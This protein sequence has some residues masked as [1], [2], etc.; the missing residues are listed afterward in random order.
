MNVI[1]ATP[2]ETP[3]VEEALDRLAGRVG[4][5]KASQ[6]LRTAIEHALNG[7]VERLR[8]RQRAG[9]TVV[10]GV[11]QTKRGGATSQVELGRNLFGDEFAVR[12]VCDCG[13]RNCVHGAAVA[14]TALLGLPQSIGP[15]E[16]ERAA[17]TGVTLRLAG[18]R[19]EPA[20]GWEEMFDAGI[21]LERHRLPVVEFFGTG[22]DG[23]RTPLTA[24]GALTGDLA[25]QAVE[26]R[27]LLNAALCTTLEPIEGLR[28]PRRTRGH[29]FVVEALDGAT[30]DRAT[31]IQ[32]C[33]EPQEGFARH[34]ELKA[35][36]EK[37]GWTLEVDD[38]WPFRLFDDPIPLTVEFRENDEGG[39]AA[40]P[41]IKL[42]DVEL[43]IEESVNA[44]AKEV[45]AAHPTA[46]TNGSGDEDDAAYTVIR[47]L[48][49]WYE[50]PDGRFGRPELASFAALVRAAISLSRL[51]RDAGALSF[52]AMTEALDD[53]EEAEVEIDMP[54]D[55]EKVVTAIKLLANPPPAAAPASLV[56]K[57]KPHQETGL[58]W[59]HILASMEMGGILADEMGLGKSLTTAS[60]ICERQES[61][62]AKGPS[63]IV[64]PLAMLT[65]WTKTFSTFYPHMKAVIAHGQKTHVAA[66]IE[67]AEPNVIV[68]T[69]GHVES[70][71]AEFQPFSWDVCGLDE[72]QAAK[73]ENT[74]IAEAIRSLDIAIPLVITGTPIEN[75]LGELRTHLDWCCPGVLGTK[76]QF[77]QRFRR[78]IESSGDDTE[79]RETAKRQLSAIVSPF[80]LRRTKEILTDLPPKTS[81]V[82]KV[83]FS[84]EERQLYDAIRVQ[85]EA[86]VKESVARK[87]FSAAKMD[88]LTAM[89]RMKQVCCDARLLGE[90]GG[91]G[92]MPSAKRSAL[93]ELL[94][95][96]IAA[97]H[98]ILVFSQFRSMLD[99]VED[100]IIAE[101]WSYAYMHGGVS[102][103][104]RSEQIARFQR[105]EMD[106][107]LITIR[108]GGAG[109]TLTAADTVVF[110]DY[111]WNPALEMQAEARAH[112]I[113]QD[114]EVRV[115]RLVIEKSIEEGILAMHSRKRDLATII[116]PNEED[117]GAGI[118]EDDIRSLLSY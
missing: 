108:S 8:R 112:R 106:V 116:G 77:G 78:A 84:P 94:R 34:D 107:F 13:T 111:W 79:K 117:G 62:T 12:W 114:R 9:A 104:T 21:D 51:G 17:W 66:L 31:T 56:G 70:R 5:E 113:G 92:R 58:G 26:G 7:K 18:V 40:T 93:V 37:L 6:R 36:C 96:D 23:T 35:L 46:F 80:A 55:L 50:M 25:R 91:Y 2:E 4:A 101:G 102:T 75:N 88:I 100:D 45:L 57:L 48:T 71:T 47:R 59:L 39:Y 95:T 15:D 28:L 11:F 67:E 10:E 22:P 81:E 1:A 44:T 99:L 27:A 115:K 69:Y 54:P 72:A 85:T 19:V 60:F 97:G 41:V 20:A 73:N 90:A 87:G 109:I 61:G 42:G 83:Q 76:K 49:P 89:M 63:L 24:D 86:K 103:A 110:L 74:N 118:T 64:C 65:E 32:N 43:S 16:D 68:T 53:L 33:L 30:F 3:T 98:R 38:S 82:I 29:V 52:G 105:K 14:A